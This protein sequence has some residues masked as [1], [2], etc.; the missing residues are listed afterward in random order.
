MF[1]IRDDEWTL[2]R[3][4]WK[5]NGWREFAEDSIKLR[6]GHKPKNRRI[7][8]KQKKK[9]GWKE[10][11]EAG[12]GTDFFNPWKEKKKSLRASGTLTPYGH[13]DQHEIRFLK[14]KTY[15]SHN[16]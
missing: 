12:I 3:M 11:F 10:D 5:G 7:R 6:V 16:L 2:N 13:T 8:R 1:E 9:I 14:A 4:R 15:L